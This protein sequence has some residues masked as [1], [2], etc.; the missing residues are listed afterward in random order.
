MTAEE[1]RE[2]AQILQ[3]N[4]VDYIF[5]G[6]VAIRNRYRSDT[7]DFDVMVL[8]RDFAGAIERIDHDPSVASM[9]RG[10]GSMPGGHVIVRGELVRFDI[11]DPAAYAGNRTGSEFYSYV[12]RYASEPSALGRVAFPS[13]VW[14]MRLVIDRYELYFTKMRRDLNAGVPISTLREARRIAT[15]FGVGPLMARRVAQ[16][17][18]W[19]RVAGVL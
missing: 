3:R 4:R 8:P 19:A 5:V 12:R 15:R 7:V 6:G 18:E 11:L 1:A 14:Y 9:T 17:E 2:F 13:V 16:F 10:P